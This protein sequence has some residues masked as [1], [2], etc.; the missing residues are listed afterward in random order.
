MKIMKKRKV[1]EAGEAVVTIAENLSDI[2]TFDAGLTKKFKTRSTVREKLLSDL[3][4]AGRAKNLLQGG[5][6]NSIE[7]AS[8][9]LI[10][11]SIKDEFSVRS[12]IYQTTGQEGTLADCCMF[13]SGCPEQC[14]GIQHKS[15][16]VIKKENAGMFAFSGCDKYDGLLLIMTAIVGKVSRFYVLSGAFL[17]TR[18]CSIKIPITKTSPSVYVKHEINA[19]EFA[20][21]LIAAFHR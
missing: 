17:K 9:A 8:I 2:V 1:G 21:V 7:P 15:T 18:S 10:Q 5:N 4:L 14:L 6:C 3:Q 12:L 16:G 11:A 20:D 13:L 19:N